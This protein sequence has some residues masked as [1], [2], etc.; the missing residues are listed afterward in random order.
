MGPKMIGYEDVAGRLD[1]HGAVASLRQGHLRPKAQVGD[2]FLG[3]SDRTLLNRSAYIEGLGFGVKAV[4]IYD[5]NPQK[6]L[7]SIQGGMLV[8]DADN[9]HLTAVIDAP[10]VTEYKTAGDS[11]LGAQILARPDSRRLLIVGAGTLATNLVRAYDAIFPDLERIAVWARRREQAEA[12]VASLGDL[13]GRL[14]VA[15]DLADEVGRADIVS[16]ATMA[17]QPVILGEWVQPG[18][19]VDLIGAYTAEMREADDALMAKGRVFVDSYETTVDLIGELIDPIASGAIRREDV[20]GDLYDLARDD[21]QGRTSPEDITVFKNGGGA[22]LD[23]M[24]AIWIANA[25][26]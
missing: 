2:L 19:H 23:L 4:T 1:W 5:A 6:G 11:V 26:A 8:Y 18:T 20:L 10:L 13:N 21:T 16:T 14:V 9:G 24:I 17:R 22:H 12:L 25:A 3:P 15:D 7:P